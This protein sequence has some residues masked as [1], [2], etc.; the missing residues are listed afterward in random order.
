MN[1]GVEKKKTAK[2]RGRKGE[3]LMG[4]GGN[5]GEEGKYAAAPAG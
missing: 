1:N 3:V 4:N 5:K 2:K